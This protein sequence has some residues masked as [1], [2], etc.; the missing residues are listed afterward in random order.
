MEYC[1]NYYRVV[2][3]LE[4]EIRNK[5]DIRND[6]ITKT[7]NAEMVWTTCEEGWRQYPDKANN[8]LE[9]NR[10][11]KIDKIVEN[12]VWKWE[13]NSGGRRQQKQSGIETV[14]QEL[15][16]NHRGRSRTIAFCLPPDS[17]FR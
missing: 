15:R 2:R 5:T 14:T 6:A 4:K 13:K 16:K 10:L 3:I 8:G 12:N 11:E 7:E 9:A 1:T 17:P